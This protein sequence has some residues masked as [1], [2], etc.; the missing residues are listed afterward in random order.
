MVEATSFRFSSYL[1]EPESRMVRSKK[2]LNSPART[3]GAESQEEPSKSHRPGRRV[4]RGPVS[5]P[6]VQHL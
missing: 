6:P 5:R 4:R 3:D 1:A 2:K